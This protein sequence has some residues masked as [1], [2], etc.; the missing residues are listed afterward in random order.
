MDAVAALL[1]SWSDERGSSNAQ[2][3]ARSMA[4]IQCGFWTGFVLGGCLG[5]RRASLQFLAEHQHELPGIRT[6][7]E[8]AAFM[9]L[10]NSRIMLEFGRVGFRQGVKIAV[11]AGAFVLFRWGVS[12]ARGKS[13][14]QIP[15]E[16]D[17]LL[18]AT[19]TGSLL[20]VAGKGQ[21]LYYL[22]RGLLIGGV[23]GLALCSLQMLVSL[24]A[25]RNNTVLPSN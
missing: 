15:P 13:I 4:L 9:R 18:A 17:N 1:A 7:R 12:V 16:L 25:H 6:R 5:V 24:F 21:R 23:S 14:W 11:V 10:R 22:K 2:T 8:A 20:A 19:A 3:L